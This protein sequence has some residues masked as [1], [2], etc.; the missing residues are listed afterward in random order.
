MGRRNT[1]FMGP[2]GICDACGRGC[3]TLDQ[4]GRRC[5]HCE[6]G[7]F[8]HRSELKMVPCELCYGDG[9][10]CET[11]KRTGMIATRIQDPPAT[12]PP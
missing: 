9:Y 5:Y 6:A 11:C 8:V 4:A 1:R 2:A 10:G 7:T 12:L 3:M